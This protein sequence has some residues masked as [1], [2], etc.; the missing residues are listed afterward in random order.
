[1]LAGLALVLLANWIVG[2]QELGVG[3]QS[4]GFQKS[5]SMQKLLIAT[6]DCVGFS[7]VRYGLI[8]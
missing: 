4:H 5:S 2:W 3:S 1:M 7:I 6:S 8:L